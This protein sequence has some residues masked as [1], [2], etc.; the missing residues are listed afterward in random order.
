M[1]DRRTFLAAAL[2]AAGG[3]AT[4]CSSLPGGL[5]LGDTVRV[6]VPWSGAE[7][8]AFRAVLDRLKE[9]SYELIPLGDDIG[10]ALQT[11]AGRRPDVVLLPQPGLVARHRDDLEPLPAD[12]PVPNHPLWRDLLGD[13]N[14]SLYGLP[15]KVAHKSAIW[16]RRSVVREEPASWSDWLALNKDLVGSPV[17]PLALAGADGWCLTD[18]FENV[19]LGCDPAAYDSLARSE[20][21][22][23]STESA[24]GEAL[25][26]LGRMWAVKGVLA[27]GVRGSLVR[28]YSDAVVEVFAY[29]SAAMAVVPDFAEPVIDTFAKYPDDVGVFSFPKVDLGRCGQAAVPPLIVGGDFAV[30]LRPAHMPARD[31]V[32]QLAGA[33]A[34]LPWIEE[35]GGFISANL[36]TDDS[37]YS[38]WLQELVPDLRAPET[39]IRFDLSDRLGRLG[40]ATGLWRVL[41]DFL[42]NVGGRGEAAVPGAVDKAIRQL[43]DLEEER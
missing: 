33:D 10:T 14:G 28:Q 19:L 4:G 30:L 38:P 11:R 20:N 17:A 2:G 22:R 3:A 37:V 7:L 1:L 5:G 31:L 27:G 15:F 41:Q 25:D 16:Y 34:A 35:P 18:F 40:G 8:R 29:R 24:V 39:K 36:D 13:G 26:L 21:P 6:A 23:L 9:V 12:V 42:A 32:R 43:A